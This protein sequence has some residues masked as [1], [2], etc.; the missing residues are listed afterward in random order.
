MLVYKYITYNNTNVDKQTFPCTSSCSRVSEL[1]FLLM[2]LGSRL[3]FSLV[4]VSDSCSVSIWYWKMTQ[5]H[6]F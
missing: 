1:L 5:K 4:S 6:T 2:D 3:L